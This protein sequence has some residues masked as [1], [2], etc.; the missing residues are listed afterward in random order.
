MGTALLA[1]PSC[2][3]TWTE[4]YQTEDSYTANE[5]LWEL[6]ESREELS[7]FS[8][9]VAKA[10]FYRDEHHAAISVVDGDTSYYTFKDILSANLPVTV[11]APKNEAL[12]EEEWN[13]FDAMAENDG[14]NL[15][16]Q[17][18]GNH[19]ALYRKT[20]TKTGKET[21]RL[22]NS[23]FATIDYDNAMLQKSKVEEMNIGA[24]NGLLHVL[25]SKNDFLYNLYEY[26]KFSGEVETF[27]KY[28]VKRDTTYFKEDASIEGLPDENGNPTY[29][30]SVYF[31]DN[32]MFNRDQENPTSIDATD[33]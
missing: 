30:D 6:L 5:T 24:S 23:K 17:F 25:E 13:K 1:V 12:T 14:Y 2:T 9:I 15:Q 19:I 26:I 7:K 29:V 20:M 3:D 16:Q 11:W 10:K 27:S 4:H 22:I 18:L 28:L 33:A 21:F 32:M 31:Q 8:S